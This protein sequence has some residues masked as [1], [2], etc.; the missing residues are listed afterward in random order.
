MTELPL[1]VIDNFLQ[2]YNLGQALFLAFV[3]TVLALLPLK[4]KKTISL[5]L[6]VFG[7]VFVLLPSFAAPV[8][9]RL[10]GIGL[11]VVSPI[12]YSIAD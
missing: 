10:L 9:W 8:V 1:Q 6:L 7:V 12:L 3:L 5:A 4:S 2:P 11:L